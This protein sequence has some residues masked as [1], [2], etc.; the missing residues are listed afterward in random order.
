LPIVKLMAYYRPAELW[1]RHGL[2]HPGG[3]DC[4]GQIDVIPHELDPDALR[5]AARAVP[6]ELAE[7]LMW[8]GNA[9][10][11]A[12]RVEPFVAAGASHLVLGD[13]TGTTYAPEDAAAILGAQLPRLRSLLT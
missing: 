11:I 9:D 4:R 5:E 7:E 8:I 12:A 13:L 1:R 6:L 10:E 2:E 3:P